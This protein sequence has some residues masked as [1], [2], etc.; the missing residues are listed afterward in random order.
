MNIQPIKTEQDYE[1]ALQR[2][3]QLMDADPGTVDEDELEVWSILVE[4]Y[5]KRHYPIPL[6]NPIEAIKFRMEQ[7]GL[8]PRD[9]VPYLGSRFKV[10]EILAG[11]RGLS[12]MMIRQ[13]NNSLNI[14]LN[15][16]IQADAVNIR[17]TAR[18]VPAHAISKRKAI[19]A[20][21]RKHMIVCKKKLKPRKKT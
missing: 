16:L 8:A 7:M 4:D 10:S 2:V 1:A 11:K 17:R 20:K 12:I 19:A 21:K 6:P 9:L 18:Q 3:E 14:P 5:E 15:V 13:L